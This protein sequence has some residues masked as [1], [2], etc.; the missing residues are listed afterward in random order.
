MDSFWKVP[1][2]TCAFLISAAVSAHAVTL[3]DQNQPLG[4]I[5]FCSGNNLCGQSFQQ[6]HTNIAGAGVLL[7]GNSIG[8]GTVTISIYGSYGVTPT[9]L[10][11]SG[12]VS[13]SAPSAGQWAD[14]FWSPASISL[15]TTY[16]LV[17]DVSNNL[18]VDALGAGNPYP[19]GNALYAGCANCWSQDLTFR[20]YYDNSVATPL[21][22]ALPLFATGLA[23]L[24]FLARRRRKQ[25]A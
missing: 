12:S 1:F 10:I 18:T 6:D 22:A 19:N 20:T 24:A 23:G 15:A 17:L 16:Y 14:V 9:N 4:N 13:V 2:L 7:G 8:S 5:D 25:A 3:I 21:P 11:A